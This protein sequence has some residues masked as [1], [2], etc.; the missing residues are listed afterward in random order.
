MKEEQSKSLLAEMRQQEATETV[1]T[2][3]SL[4]AAAPLAESGGTLLLLEPV[5]GVHA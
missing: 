2:M 1:A 3:M 5:I 4:A